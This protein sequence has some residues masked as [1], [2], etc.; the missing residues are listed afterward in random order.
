MTIA[1]RIDGI[2]RNPDGSINLDATTQYPIPVTPSGQGLQ[3]GSMAALLQAVA[4]AEAAIAQK[5]PLLALAPFLKI[6]PTL[7]DL[8]RPVGHGTVIDMTGLTQVINVF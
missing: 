1:C 4:D 6:D 3:F 7:Q 2:T 8:E 5:L